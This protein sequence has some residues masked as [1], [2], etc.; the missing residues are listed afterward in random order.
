MR[1]DP[2]SRNRPLAGMTRSPATALG[3]PPQRATDV[4]RRP[5][6]GEA[7]CDGAEALDARSAQTLV[8]FDIEP[9]YETARLLYE[10]PWVAE[11]YLV[12]RKLIAR[13]RIRSTR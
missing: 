7:Y 9:F 3:V 13:R 4:L 2:F 12:V 5:A 10:G 11:R 6:F 1:A 8:E